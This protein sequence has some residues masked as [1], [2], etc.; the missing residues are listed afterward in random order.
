MTKVK[1]RWSKHRELYDQW[2]SDYEGSVFIPARKSRIKG[3]CEQEAFEQFEIRLSRSTSESLYALAKQYPGS[4]SSLFQGLW[5]SLLLK[6]SGETD[7]LFAISHSACKSFFENEPEVQLARI[8]DQHFT[9]NQLFH[10]LSKTDYPRFPLSKLC[11]ATGIDEKAIDHLVVIANHLLNQKEFEYQKY[12]N[13]CKNQV[14]E[15][16][17]L[18]PHIQLVVTFVPAKYLTIQINYEPNRYYSELI[19]R[20]GHHLKKMIESIIDQPHLSIS[21]FDLITAEEKKKLH[22]FNQ[23][24]QHY[25]DKETIHQLIESRARQSPDQ[26]A[27]E[28]LDTRLT[29]REL[30]RRADLLAAILQD[31]NVKKGDIV[32]VMVP[33]SL[34]MIIGV[35]GILKAGAAYLPID[36]NYPSER[37]SYMLKDSKTQMLLTYG[38]DSNDIGTH[39]DRLD[40]KMVDW[41]KEAASRPDPMVQV[42]DPAYVIYTSGSTGKPKGVMIEHSS[43]VNLAFWHVDEFKISEYDCCTKYAGFSFDASVWEIFPTL[44]A[45]ATLQIIDEELRYD[46]EELNRYMDEKGVTVSFLPTQVAEQF[47]HLENRSLRIL[48]VGGDRLK[49]VVPQTYKIVNNYGP[50]ENT[51]VTTS[52][53]VYPDEPIFIGRPIANNR[54]YVLSRQQ[55]LQ[56]VGAPGELCI[57]GAGLAR[58]YLHR[59]E[60]TAE[61]FVENPF[62]PGERMYKTGDIV[63]WL[64]DGRLEFLGRIDDQV[65]IRGFRIELGEI[66]HCL[67]QHPHIQ[68]ALVLTRSDAQGR[69]YLCA[70]FTARE[71]WTKQSI[72]QHLEQ[73]LPYYMVPAHLIHMDRFPLT[74]N[75][76]V[77][78]KALP[79]PETKG[80]TNRSMPGTSETERRLIRIWKEIFDAGQVGAA[81]NFFDLGGDSLKLMR[82]LSRIRKEFQVRISIHD[83]YERPV[84]RDMAT[85]IWKAE[86]ILQ[87]DVFKTSRPGETYPTSSV[88]KRIYAVEQLEN[89]G[90]TYHTPVMLELRG[91]LDEKRLQSAF[92]NFVQRHEALRTS[93]HLADGE[94]VQ[95]VQSEVELPWKVYRA[96][97]MDEVKQIA[98]TFISPFDLGK[99]PLFRVALIHHP[100][101]RHYLVIDM[102]H[103]VSDGISVEEILYRELGALYK[104]EVLPVPDLQYKDYAAWQ[105]EWLKSEECRKQ[106]EYWLNR[107]S[108][109]IPVL[110]LPTDYQRPFVQEFAGDKVRFSVGA[111]LTERLKRIAK[112]E[113]ST[114]FMM[115]FAAYKVLLAKLSGQED[116][117]AGFPVAG[118]GQPRLESVFGMFVNTLPLRSQ[119]CMDLSFSD[120]LKQVRKRILEAYEHG[121]YP[122]EEVVEQLKINRDRSRNPL[123][124]TAFVLQNMDTETI[125][126]PGV[127]VLDMKEIP[128][129]QSMFDMTWE[130]KEEAETIEF[131]VEYCTRLFKRSTIQRF[132][133]S[134]LTILEQITHNPACTIAKIELL[135]PEEKKKVLVEFNRTDVPYPRG[136]TI[137]QLFEEQVLKT[138]DHVA[139]RMG[140]ETL[141]YQELNEQTN[142]LARLLRGKGIKR[143][144][145]VGL[146]VER[147]PVMIIGLLAIVKAG[148]TYLPI[149]PGYPEER[150]RFMLEDSQANTLLVQPGLPVPEA[151]T[152]RLV[153]LSPKIWEDQYSGNLPNINLPEDILYIIYTSGSTGTPKGITTMHYNVVRTIVNNGYVEVDESDRVL[154]LSN[155]AFDGSTFDIYMSLLHGA[156]LV[157][158]PKET[159]LDLNKLT[160]LIREEKITV[161]F[162][163]TALFN[164]LVDFDLSSLANMRKILFGGEKASVKHVQKAVR[165]LGEH[166]LING[167]GPT[168]T[169][170]FATT[171][172]IDN[173]VLATG[174][175]PI[176]KPLNNTR[177]YVLNG[178][179]QLQPVGVSGELCISGDGVAKGYLNRP[180]LTRERFVEDPFNPGNRMYKTGDLVRWLEDGTIEYL[181]RMDMQVKIRG[182]R[183]ELGEIERHLMEEKE[184]RDAVVIKDEDEQGSYLCAY[185]VADTEI[186]TASLRKRLRQKL[187]DYMM[188]SYFVELD[189]IPL[190]ANGKVDKRSLPKPDFTDQTSENYAE[191]TTETEAI[192]VRVWQ[193]VL[194]IERVGIHDNFF[195]LGGDSIKAI[196][197]AARLNQQQIKLETKTLFRYPTI[198][199][200]APNVK[201]G[202]NRLEEEG[203]ITGAVH[204]TPIQQWFFSLQSKKPNHFNQAMMLYSADGWNLPW[205]KEAFQTLTKHHDALRMTYDFT[206]GEV[207]QFNQPEEHRAFTVERLD[208]KEPGS[209]SLEEHANRLQQSLNL[210]T[211]PLVRAG[212]FHND[213]GDYL[214]IVIHHLVVDGVSWRIIL[215]DFKTAY[216]QAANGQKI[217]LPQK[218]SSFR[219]WA[220]QLRQYADSNKM[221]QE[222]SYWQQLCSGKIEALPKDFAWTGEKLHRDI[223]EFE[224]T[225]DEVQTGQL[226]TQVHHA[227]HTEVNDL[228]LAGLALAINEWTGQS[229][230][231]LNL[232]GH[233]REEIIGGVD[234]NR[235]VGWFTSMYPVVFELQDS[236]LSRVI[237]AIKEILRH[238]P[239]KGIGYG[240]LRYLTAP[241]QKQDLSFDLEP[242]ISFNYLGQFEEEGLGSNE[243]PTGDWFSPLTPEP[244]A[245][246]FNSMVTGGRLKIRVGYNTRMFKRQTVE[247]VARSFIKHLAECIEHC[248]EK[249]NT[250]YTP[251]DF[252]TKDL[253]MAELEHIYS[254]LPADRIQ[255]IYSLSSLQ[256]G[257]LF[258]AIQTRIQYFEQFYIDLDGAV[259]FAAFKQSLEKLVQK[260]DVLRTVFMFQNLAQ[261]VQVVLKKVEVPILYEDLSSLSETKQQAFLQKFKRE[262]R[263]KG[264][265]ALHEP[266]LRFALFK[267]ADDRFHFVWSFHHILFDGWCI[268]LL[269]EDWLSM[270]QALLQG[271]SMQLER[272]TPYREYIRW[273]EEQDHE[274][275]KAFWK[276]YLRGYEQTASVLNRGI[277]KKTD[278]E[279][280]KKETDFILPQKLTERLT[281]LAQQYHV[282]PSTFFQTI[283]GILLQKYNDTDDVVFGTVVSGRPSELPQV[284]KMVGLFINTVPIRIR[285]KEYDTFA[286]LLQRVQHEILEA[287]K[288]HYA[289]LAEIQSGT[290]LFNKLFDHIMAFEN[291]P[292]DLNRFKNRKEEP[293]FSISGLDAFE[294]DSYGVGLIVYPGDE[295]LVKLKYDTEIYTEYQ[296]KQ[297]IDHLQT[298]M[299]QILANPETPVHQLEIIPHEEKQRLLVDFN[300]TKADYARNVAIHQLFE[301][302]VEKTPQNIALVYKEKE[303]TYKELNTRAN[304]LARILRNNKIDREQ[305]VGIMM[306]RSP[307]FIISIL[308]ILKAGGAYLPIDPEY[309]AKR[310]QY[311]LDDSQVKLLLVQPGLQV[312]ANYREN[313]LIVNESLLQGDPSNLPVVNQPTD[314]AYLIYTS[315]STGKPK[316]VMVEHRNLCNLVLIA[317]PYGIHEN[318]RVLQFASVSFDASVAE[319]F[320]TLVTGA[321]LYLEEKMVLLNQLVQYLREKRISN[322]TLPPSVLKSVSYGELPDL[323]TIISAGETCSPDLVNKWGAGRTF[324]NAYGPTEATV[325]ATI[326]KYH[327]SVSETSIG[328]PFFNQQVY[329]VNKHHQLQPIGVPG[330]LCISGAGLARGYWNLPDLTADKFVDNPFVPGTKMYRTGDLAC[331]L[332]DGNIEYL[333]RVDDQVKIRGYRVEL[334]EIT[335]QL[336]KYPS[337]K[338]ATVVAHEGHMEQ[339]YLCAY[340][341]AEGDWSVTKLRQH[342]IKELPEYMIPSY[343]VELERIP[344]TP[345][346]KIDKKALPEPTYS[347]QANT[348]PASP[349]NEVE[350]KLVQIWEEVLGL[351]SVGIHDD[352]FELGGD[353]IKAIQIISRLH[354][355]DFK[356]KINDLFDNPTICE[357]APCIELAEAEADQDH[358][359]GEVPL[360]PIQHWFFEQ[361]FA[362]LHHWNQSMMLFH[363]DGFDSHLVKQAFLKLVEHHDALRMVFEPEG[364]KWVQRIRGL[365]EGEFFTFHEFDFRH[366]TDP[367][368][369]I[370]KVADELQRSNDLFQGRLVQLGLFRTN[371]GDHLLIVIHHLLID[372]IS[373]RILLEDFAKVYQQ[374]SASQELVLPN[375]TSSYQ[376][377]SKRL[378]EYANTPDA[379][380]ELSYWKQV[381]EAAVPS[382]PKDYAPP[383]Q[384]VLLDHETVT[385]QLTEEETKKLLTGVHHAYHTEINDLLLTA[386][387]LALQ[388]WTGENKAVINLEGHGR[389]EIMNELDISRTVGWFTSSYPVV[390]HLEKTDVGEAIKQIK[391]QLRKIP[392]KG[393]GYGILKYLTSPQQKEGIGFRVQPEISFNYLGQF[394]RD[395]DHELFGPSVMPKGDEV[396]PLSS[397]PY[398]LNIY[399]LVMHHRLEMHFDYNQKIHRA[400]TI[401]RVA[402]EFMSKLRLI[403]EHCSSKEEEWTPSDFGSSDLTFEELED[404][405]DLLSD[406]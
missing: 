43:L 36:P 265:P 180:D 255:D 72:R 106:K 249:E 215:E 24:R 266:L 223:D 176:G 104:G 298:L 350:E 285:S 6:Y 184:V 64:P 29:Y 367:A 278:Y 115:L 150:I 45:G 31:R 259:D 306:K 162:I 79:V 195:E 15:I 315:G 232:E 39:L 346:G 275:A 27:V 93:F 107:L 169:T 67:L 164:M 218:T 145:V 326:A 297:V 288:V 282:T 222:K 229:K 380:A 75:G 55:Q 126:L 117:I 341:T 217:I 178:W 221:M 167:Y 213:D 317:K 230:I 330:E 384:R 323:K 267:L 242:E 19:R 237:P 8:R 191:P 205:V 131:S 151:Y 258:H 340:F 301:K 174:C 190:T 274:E 324:I 135:P 263:K 396:S 101:Q 320:P 13:K 244:H 271:T 89:I 352:F 177:L 61:K 252:N 60:L 83:L 122:L 361:N 14:N 30:N 147:S 201:S 375:K 34:E 360:T 304:Q 44:L 391:E 235:T 172:S 166:R 302:Q 51:V 192:L 344:L 371:Q 234:L 248:L 264:F 140:E 207:K 289:S 66:A 333:G 354:Q 40:L 181:G 254:V 25:P 179:G 399:G 382:L 364:Q 343:F 369:K 389:E 347:V 90:T 120:Y 82:L 194:G 293:G 342:L 20:M 41:T 311:M 103:I 243:I 379:L 404:I 276:D 26:T 273:L 290:P 186:E 286:T 219:T 397:S 97:S 316:G 381:E 200:L 171:C 142:Q 188:P 52:G 153:E 158:V 160:R 28:F 245:L 339:V 11:E 307:E 32:A 338:E 358:V 163:T 96:S 132:I 56:P 211:G 109:S 292:L 270:Y 108:G 42:H 87:N 199:E 85:S 394:D 233:G 152:G 189:S 71:G 247:S 226:L 390:L 170:V 332:P 23:T 12:T 10:A 112:Q 373:W 209:K 69:N 294:Q 351:E 7:V 370:R 403:I 68:D 133:K 253:S 204:L 291:Y 2:L 127:S 331:W 18:D 168:E 299:E 73:E 227:Y 58:G 77:D 322:V 216:H 128:W 80:K 16:R 123:F 312:P 48:L 4:L 348:E 313:V 95:K 279:L 33:P 355:L 37:I 62:E 363:P 377:W 395:F 203:E 136:K 17:K 241:E 119:P 240:I 57:S 183:I 228:L 325:C 212:I 114:L 110:E 49:Q 157:L 308:A 187:P 309:P 78:K 125:N 388:K 329:I 5:G 91:E 353:S 146:L 366:E 260:H 386:L 295:W 118:R 328:K 262:D 116:I 141:T 402:E 284:E 231:A 124:D 362:N 345:N 50:T 261:P 156:Q 387:L 173:S 198:A 335:N 193:E 277:R 138:P 398:L 74:P 305:I 224:L 357:L 130:A 220:K 139:I 121:D 94:V 296:M 392:N 88:Q 239:N 149:D 376:R 21:E 92:E 318:T 374:A 35:L 210:E 202:L 401:T 113:N 359:E 356:L 154:Q 54:V 111:S 368:P 38:N 349:T 405:S 182:H 393:I 86:T 144:D 98:E 65:K 236:R 46:L 314:L 383:K 9:F 161:S 129:K 269:L 155:Y 102:H 165:E 76:K 53:P 319:V 22:T 185:F 365:E 334:G 59:P 321:T 281:S 280:E 100:D 372:G 148:G 257:I 1:E 214:L 159:L 336:I 238:I 400:E 197:I 143:G 327:D 268:S 385:V 63:R 137:Q 303:W 406:L 246:A 206:G 99:A 70:Y 208:L 300:C 256:K 81:D 337:I 84:L 283:W 175:V 272:V 105:Q 251:S 287:E 250:T 225:L 134:Y 378:A 196:R 3:D 47:M 310:I